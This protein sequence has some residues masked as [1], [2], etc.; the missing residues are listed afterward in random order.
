MVEEQGSSASILEK[1]HQH[2]VDKEAKK[3][4]K[5]EDWHPSLKKLVRFAASLD[6]LQPA[7]VIPPSYRTVRLEKPK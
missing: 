6:G 7:P 3:K 4:E 1:M 5:S 2:S